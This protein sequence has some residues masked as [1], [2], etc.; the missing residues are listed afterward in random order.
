MITE[1]QTRKVEPD[2]TIVEVSGQLHAGNTLLSVENTLKRLIESGVKK[3]IVDL[4]KVKLIDSSGIGV[5]VVCNAQIRQAGGMLRI[6]C[7]PGA[8][9]HVLD[10]VNI[11]QV[12]P[13]DPDVESACNKFLAASA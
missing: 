4:A 3:L 8:V 9:G 7:P 13:I 10:L 12:V 1:I 5:L 2:T 11:S 6:A